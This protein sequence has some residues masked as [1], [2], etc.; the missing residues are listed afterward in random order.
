VLAFC[1]TS[2]FPS[3]ALPRVSSRELQFTSYSGATS[4]SACKCCGRVGHLME[5][6]KFWPKKS[7]GRKRTFD[8]SLDE[9][10]FKDGMFLQR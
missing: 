9:R 1:E 6:C 4:T 5:V 2:M 10:V 8:N 7:K 3:D